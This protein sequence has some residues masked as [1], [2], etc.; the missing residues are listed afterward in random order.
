MKIWQQQRFNFSL[1]EAAQDLGANDL[2]TFVRVVLPLTI[3]LSILLMA[4]V[5]IP[6]LIYFHV[7]EEAS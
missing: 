7:S 2:G 1:V 5:L 3:A 4:V 6:V